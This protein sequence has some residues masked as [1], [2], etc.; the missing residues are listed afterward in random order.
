MIAAA[1]AITTIAATPPTKRGLT[2]G[3]AAVGAV[4]EG[5]VAV[6]L[7]AVVAVACMTMVLSP[8]EM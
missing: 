1:T 7:V 6:V 2:P 4:V 8:P 3:A 5:V